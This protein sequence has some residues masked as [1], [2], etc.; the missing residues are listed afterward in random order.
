M[1]PTAQALPDGAAGTMGIAGSWTTGLLGLNGGAFDA[2]QVT[3][4]IVTMLVLVVG[5]LFWRL[6]APNLQGCGAEHDY[7]DHRRR[8][9]AASIAELLRASGSRPARKVFSAMFD[10]F[11]EVLVTQEPIRATVESAQW[12]EMKELLQESLGLELRDALNK[13]NVGEVENLHLLGSRAH[14][15]VDQTLCSEEMKEADVFLRK[16]GVTRRQQLLRL[17]GFCDSEV[18][19]WLVLGLVIKILSQIPQP[20][21]M[22]YVSATVTAAARG[23]EGLQ[24]FHAA[25]LVCFWLFVAEK[26]LQF[27]GRI[28]M[29]RGEQL[30]TLRLKREV[31]AACLRQDMEFFDS[32]QTGELQVRLNGDTAEICQ[33][34]LYFPVR[35]IQ[36]TFFL[37]FN[38]LTLLSTTPSLVLATLSV[39]PFS[40]FG[41][42]VLMRRLQKHYGK[43]QRRAEVSASKTQEVLGN[44]RT[45]RAFA[46]E[47]H[48]LQRYMRD[49]EYEARVLSQVNLMQGMTQPLLHGIGEM[50]F[51]AGL[52]YG[53]LLITRGLLTSGEVITLVQGTQACTGVLMD[54]FDTLPEIAKAGKPISR[55]C[56]LLERPSH[57]E[58]C[59][60]L[61]QQ[62][63]N[64]NG[65]AAASG[66]VEFQDVHFSYASRRNVEVLR[67]L[68]FGASGGEV[69]ALVGVTG[70]GKST[71]VNLLLRFYTPSHGRILL[72]GKPLDTYDV[73]WLR[74]QVGVVSQE[75]L[76]FSTSIR[77]NL[78]YGCADGQAGVLGTSTDDKMLQESCVTANAWEFIQQLPE[79][80]ST[81]VGENGALLSGGQKQRIAIARALLKR[82]KVLL[83]DEA[84]SALDVESERVVQRALDEVISSSKCTTLV[85]AHRLATIQNADRIV[86]IS[87][88]TV[89]ETG[90]PRELERL[91]HGLYA[92]LKRSQDVTGHCNG[93]SRGK[94]VANGVLRNGTQS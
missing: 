84:T 49:Q 48:E 60:R 22:L 61:G 73:H 19:T 50:S 67:G 69:V 57:I 94:I 37:I 39:L 17:L 92:A 87:E 88:G 68:T 31:Y 8:R 78:L 62:L 9:A 5:A 81:E 74:R 6:S 3:A 24:D 4:G 27:A 46:R 35:F 26:L 90:P 15:L 51:F 75:P 85:I 23:A 12:E 21:R 91:P 38:L 58:K 30:F 80:L 53:G 86:V 7:W 42:I 70:C 93:S 65:A 20:V 34:V 25:V 63:V 59:P 14:R 47:P 82:P 71:V 11:E 72:D 44:I 29:F 64:S 66:F 32:R 1:V 77:D 43:M 56:D 45:V 79:G 16:Q 55:I 76:L 13:G 89:R 41:N 10:E 18:L 54:L 52:Y 33:K 40:L 28:T 36:F 2:H 83:L